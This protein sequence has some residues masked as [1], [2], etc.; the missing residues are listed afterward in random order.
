[1]GNQAERTA[2]HVKFIRRTA[3]IKKS[4]L[5]KCV[6]RKDWECRPWET[7]SGR[8]PEIALLTCFTDTASHRPYIRRFR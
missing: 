2:N 8:I 7:G 5:Q 3:L 6:G 4:K 1:M